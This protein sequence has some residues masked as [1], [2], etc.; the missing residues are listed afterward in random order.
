MQKYRPLPNVG[1]LRSLIHYNP[2]TGDFVWKS[3]T[4]DD[5]ETRRWN[6]RYS[7]T[8]AGSKVALPPYEYHSISINGHPFGAHRIAYAIM[9]GE[10]PGNDLI[11]HV[12][13]DP[14]N[15]KWGNL[16]NATITQNRYNMGMYS[17][18]TSG[19]K[20]VHCHKPSGK[21][22]ASMGV[23]GQKIPI[24]I[25]DT[26]PHAVEAY[27]RAALEIQGE[28]IHPSVDAIAA[29]EFVHRNERKLSQFGLRGVYDNRSG[30]F[31]SQIRVGRITLGLGS[32]DTAEES[33]AAWRKARDI[34][35]SAKAVTPKLSNAEICR[36]IRP[37]WCPRKDEHR[38]DDAAD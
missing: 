23:D 36:R 12:D 20:G 1:Y 11:D 2:D 34:F 10:D 29:G 19:F 37:D 27:R 3:K 35:E 26:K 30:K 15:N 22:V 7:G 17:N 13:E 16:R 5:R 31:G 8:K 25:Y 18:N 6:S 38:F 4:G 32:Y 21:W 28:F 24:G 9:T 14:L 33:S